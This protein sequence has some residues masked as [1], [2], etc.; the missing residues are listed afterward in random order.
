MT[1]LDCFSLAQFIISKDNYIQFSD[2]VDLRSS[3]IVTVHD[4]Q[5][6]EKAMA[7]QDKAFKQCRASASDLGLTISSRCKL[8]VP[9]TNDK[10]KENKFTK[11]QK[12]G[13]G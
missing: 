1:N 13:V 4:F 10:P 11:F 9:K 5:M 2:M 6:L 3:V 7:L 12:S 8:I